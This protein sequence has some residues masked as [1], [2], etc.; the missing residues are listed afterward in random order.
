MESVVERQVRVINAD[1]ITGLLDL[2][3]NS[4]HTCVTSP[5][6]FAMR[7]YGVD[8]QIGLG[9]LEEYIAMMRNVFRHVRRV[10][11]K[12]GTLWLNLGDG[13]N[14]YNSNRGPAKGANKNHHAVMPKASKGLTVPELKNKDLLGV[15]WRVALALQEDGWFLR[16]DIIWEKPNPM[17][18]SVRDRCVKAHE[19]IFL[20]SK[21][22][23]YHCDT[24]A[25]RVPHKGPTPEISL[26]KDDYEK[27]KWKRRGGR[28]T[29]DRKYNPKGKVRGSV[30]SVPTKPFKNAHFATFPPELI[31]PCIR[32]GAPEGGIVLDPFAGSGTTGI[33]ARD[34]GRYAVL[35]E[36]KKQYCQMIHTRLLRE[37]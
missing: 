6:Y 37:R 14:A 31:R 9:T 33:V 13:Y 29:R 16:Q 25:L 7:D 3:E 24:D 28:S 20:F 36:L 11:R 21:S 27:K 18:E 34:E 32:A 35:I 1:V 30:W 2:P 17:P 8:G 26:S 12:D 5:P 19:Y 10:V 15:P 23:R 4:M 22:A